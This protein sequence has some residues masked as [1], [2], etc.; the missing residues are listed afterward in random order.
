MTRS[1]FQNDGLSLAFAEHG[2]GLPFVFQHGLGANAEQ[3]FDLFAMLQGVRLIAMDARAHGESDVGIE[4]DLGFDAFGR[5]LRALFDSLHLSHAVTGGLSMGAGIALNFALRNPERVRALIL[6]RPA[7]TDEPMEARNYY[8]AVAR[9]IRQYG[10]R[11]GRERFSQSSLYRELEGRF[12][13]TA[14]SVLS[15]FDSPRAEDGVARLERMPADLPDRNRGSWVAIKCPTIVLAHKDDPVH[16]LA[17]GQVIAGG[18]PNA[19]FV[20]IVPKGED[21]E[22]HE[23]QIRSAVGE[24]LNSL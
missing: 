10:A 6:L 8:F 19:R 2:T 13:D 5:D 1:Q 9:T 20:E 24:F 14:K 15:Q 3:T 4:Q 16:P 18:I 23:S 12:P 11:A 7:W 17:C 21:R 22:L